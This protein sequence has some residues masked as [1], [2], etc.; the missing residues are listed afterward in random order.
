MHA[1]D[2]IDAREAPACLD[3]P[4]VCADNAAMNEGD[5]I[6]RYGLPPAPESLPRIR[7][8]LEAATRL[9]ADDEGD[10]LHM[11]ELCVLLFAAARVEDSLRVW[12]AKRASFDAGCSIDVQLLCGAGFEATV[13]WLRGIDDDEARH[14]LA[15]VLECERSGDFDGRDAPGGRL[16][17]VLDD[18]R[19]YYGLS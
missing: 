19:R 18:Y 8:A 15:Y 14:A 1:R 7:E 2:A 3:A 10:T 4:R 16:S 11:K 17:Q 13:D 9:E 5:A 12:R 6:A